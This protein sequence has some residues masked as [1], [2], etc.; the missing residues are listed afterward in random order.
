MRDMST[1][2][3]GAVFVFLALTGIVIRQ[4]LTDGRKGRKWLGLDQP[5]T[6]GKTHSDDILDPGSDW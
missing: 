5:P 1:W 4:A 3:I 2:I 6:P